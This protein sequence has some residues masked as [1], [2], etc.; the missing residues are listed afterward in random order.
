MLPTAP[1][2]IDDFF[3]IMDRVEQ[4]THL[5]FTGDVDTVLG[6]SSSDR[7]GSEARNAW[8]ALTSLD[9]YARHHLAGEV[10]TFKE[11]TEGAGPGDCRIDAGKC[12]PTESSQT[13][14][15]FGHHRVFPVPTTVNPAGKIMMLAH[16][17]LGQANTLAPRL[18]YYD[19]VDGTGKIYI[20]YIGPHLPNTKTAHT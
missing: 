17:R 18:H 12:V 16:I 1:E 13:V 15:Q 19:D 4:L 11:Y 9:S 5:E 6:L 8:R 20:G 3:E 7:N 10:R 14:N 2:E